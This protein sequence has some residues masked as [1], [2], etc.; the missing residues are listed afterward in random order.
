MPKPMTAP[1]VLKQLEQEGDEKVRA[2][3][4]RDGAGD[5]VFGVLFGK[6]RALAGTLGT[7][8]A[9]GLELWATGI[10]H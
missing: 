10:V 9:L 8:H 5:N 3:Y 4:V 6:I 1:Q 2:R 7:N